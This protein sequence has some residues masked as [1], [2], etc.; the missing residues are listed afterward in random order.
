MAQDYDYYV[1]ISPSYQGQFGYRQE[2]PFSTRAEAEAYRQQKISESGDSV[3]MPNILI[4]DQRPSQR[5][6]S[7]PSSLPQTRTD[8]NQSTTNVFQRQQEIEK[9]RQIREAEKQKA[10]EREKAELLKK[11]RGVS[12]APNPMKPKTGSSGKLQ[13][14]PYAQPPTVTAATE[15]KMDVE[16][17]QR[18]IAALQRNI[19][20]IQNI[21][22]G[23]SKTL[24]GNKTEFEKWASTVDEAYHEV[25]ASSQEYVLQMFIKYNLFGSLERNVQKSAYSK[26][27]AYLGSKDPSVQKWLL[28]QIR[29]EQIQLN[30]LHKVVDVGNLSGDFASLLKDGQEETKQN[31]ETL[32]FVNSLLE[33]GEIVKYAELLTH[34]KIFRELPGE[35]FSQAKMIGETYANLSAIVY[36]WYSI[37]QLTRDVEKYDRE[38]KSLSYRMRHAMKEMQCLN[39]CLENPYAK[40]LD[41]CA[42]KTGLSKPP[43]LP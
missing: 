23:Y 39:G 20:G 8:D 25:L 33:T 24:H 18:R 1:I 6:P 11:L 2:G 19:A 13:L 41:R 9:E 29:K 4:I 36:S 30:R 17:V 21:L 37:N 28:D 38:I 42:G 14:K 40:C 34:S 16:Q 3:N 10:Q 22:R 12:S 5:K 43:P 31:M 7:G 15:V 35:Y 26:L 32:L 27:G